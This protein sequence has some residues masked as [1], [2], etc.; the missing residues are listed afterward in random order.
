MRKLFSNALKYCGYKN[1]LAVFSENNHIFLLKRTIRIMIW[2][3]IIMK[4]MMWLIALFLIVNFAAMMK[5]LF[6]R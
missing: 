2:T 4:I 5:Q 1:S 3:R 6:M